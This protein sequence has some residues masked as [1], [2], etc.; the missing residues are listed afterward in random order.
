MA[1]GQGQLRQLLIGFAQMHCRIGDRRE[2][3]ECAS[4]RDFW[5]RPGVDRELACCPEFAEA[6]FGN[7]DQNFLLFRSGNAHDGLP[8]SNDL[9]RLCE[10]RADNAGKVA[11]ECAVIPLMC[12]DL[13]LA[14]CLFKSAA[15]G[16]QGIFLQFKGCL[17]NEFSRQ[18]FG[19]TVAFRQG[20]TDSFDGIERFLLSSNYADERNTRPRPTKPD[21]EH[22]R[23]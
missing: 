14:A 2:F 1:G 21:R 4:T 11:A 15:C 19:L 5:L 18:Q 9:S 8:G 7:R 23:E 20:G 12:A 6:T 3:A 17:A 10:Y 13:M 16:L 22:Y